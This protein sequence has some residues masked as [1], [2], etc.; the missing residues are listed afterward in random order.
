MCSLLH[1]STALQFKSRSFVDMV[2][3]MIGES[4]AGAKQ[5]VGEEGKFST[6]IFNGKQGKKMFKKRRLGRR[7][8]FNCFSS[9]HQL[10]Y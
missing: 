10:Y 8:D 5:L 6:L 3:I 1:S 9:F 4:T 2:F 7:F